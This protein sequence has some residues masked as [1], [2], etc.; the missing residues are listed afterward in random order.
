MADSFFGRW[1]QRKQA[2]RAGLVPDEPVPKPVA[3]PVAV[4]AS[5]SGADR[6]ALTPA[7]VVEAPAT[8]PVAP[9]AAR[10]APTLDDVTRLTPQSDFTPFVAR[11]VT[12]EVRNAA[13]KK[14]FADPHYNVMDGLDIYIDDYSKSDPIPDA[15]LR[16]MA[17]AQFLKLFEEEAEAPRAPVAAAPL[18]APGTDSFV[19]NTSPA[20]GQDHDHTDLRLQPNHAAEPQEPGRG[21]E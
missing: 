8:P 19:E 18:P 12:P 6:L 13:M 3:A 16:Q 14:L 10:P 20:L 5:V 11:E 7:P 9:A 21:T 15:M 1:S 2:V 17:S 4:V